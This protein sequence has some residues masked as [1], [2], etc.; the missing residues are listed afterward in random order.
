MDI[1]AGTIYYNEAIITTS[2]EALIVPVMS[3]KFGKQQWR[4]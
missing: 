1:E 2:L 4:W 3:K